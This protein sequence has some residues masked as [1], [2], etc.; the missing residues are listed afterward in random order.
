MEA[1][2]N[3]TNPS[4]FTP[5]AHQVEIT[6]RKD[7]SSPSY[8]ARKE[9]GHVGLKNQ[10]ATCYMNS[11]LQ[12]LYHINALR[13]A[14][15]EMPTSSEENPESSIPI[16]MQQLFW[17]LQYSP[18]RVWDMWGSSLPPSISSPPLLPRSR[19]Q[20]ASHHPFTLHI[21]DG[22]HQGPDKVVRVVRC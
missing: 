9:T 22:R 18:K 10:G 8:D 16:A 1:P 19:F 13:K 15:Y 7:P 11:L 14:V 6:V 12:T 2:P 17:K 21:Q 4:H 3:P 5:S 20:L